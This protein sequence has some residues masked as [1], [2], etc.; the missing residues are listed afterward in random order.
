MT[1]QQHLF[2]AQAQ[3]NRCVLEMSRPDAAVDAESAGTFGT[4]ILQDL[5]V[6][7]AQA[8]AA[9]RHLLREHS[10]QG[11][12]RLAP[13]QRQLLDLLLEGADTAEIARE[14]CMAQRT[15]KAHL[16]RLFLK[17]QIEGGNKRVKLAMALYPS[18]SAAGAARAES[19]LSSREQMLV[20]LVALGLRNRDIAPRLGITE[21]VVK[22]YLRILY[23]KLGVWNRMELSLWYAARAH[24]L[25]ASPEDLPI[26]P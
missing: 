22:N 20:F 10:G 24:R 23:D 17:F 11:K 8:Q 9:Q 12:L 18:D 3:L 7:I 14:L 19:R 4:S 13:R 5:C 26:Q 1:W 6:A 25:V 16:S 2:D 15:V 21:N